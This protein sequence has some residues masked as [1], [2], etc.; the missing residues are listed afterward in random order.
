MHARVHGL[1]RAP[2][3]GL[4]A[5]GIDAHVFVFDRIPGIVA[6]LCQHQPPVGFDLTHH[7]AE[8]IDMAG[9]GARSTELSSGKG[10]QERTLLRASNR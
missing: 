5:K 9:N 3:S 6:Q 1:N 10:G 4:R 2:E 7:R 8:G